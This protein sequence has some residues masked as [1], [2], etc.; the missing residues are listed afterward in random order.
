MIPS[1]MGS[2]GMRLC[3]VPMLRPSARIIPA[4]Q[5]FSTSTANK[6]EKEFSKF[7]AKEIQQE[8]DTHIHAEPPKGFSIVSREDS[9][10]TISR[11]FADSSE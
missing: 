5:Y 1:R 4:T 9:K 10:T 8:A 3:M 7:L 6:M 2:L 11:K